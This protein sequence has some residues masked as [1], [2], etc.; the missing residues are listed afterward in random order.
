MYMEVKIMNLATPD[1][2]SSKYLIAWHN[3][4]R[5]QFLI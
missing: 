4:S 3:T 1:E 2:T 5:A